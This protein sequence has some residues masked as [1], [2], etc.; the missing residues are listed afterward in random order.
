MSWLYPVKKAGAK[1]QEKNK[2]YAGAGQTYIFLPIGGIN[3]PFNSSDQLSKFYF[4][5]IF[6]SIQAT[7]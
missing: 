5:N 1:G 7:I 3:P 2:R 6:Y 4:V